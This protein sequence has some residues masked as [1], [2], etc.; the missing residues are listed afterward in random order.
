MYESKLVDVQ[1]K[2]NTE[3]QKLTDLYN[4]LDSAQTS[5]HDARDEYNHLVNDRMKELDTIF[6]ETSARRMEQLKESCEEAKSK[7][8]L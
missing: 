1:I 4:E 6:E 3:K 7:Y 5:L 8:D 2:V